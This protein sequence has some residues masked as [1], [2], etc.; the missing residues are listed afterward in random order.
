[1]VRLGRPLALLGMTAGIIIGAI[2]AGNAAHAATDQ[3]DLSWSWAD[4][5]SCNSSTETLSITYTLESAIMD[6]Y[7]NVRQAP[8]G[9]NCE[10]QSLAYDVHIKRLFPLNSGADLEW[11]AFALLGASEKSTSAPYALAGGALRPDGKPMYPV[12]LPAGRVQTVDAVLGAGAEWRGLEIG[13]GANLLPIDWSDGESG[14]T[15]HAEVAAEFEILWGALEVAADI[16]T[17]LGGHAYGS[18]RVVWRGF[19]LYAGLYHDW[20]LQ[21]VAPDAPMTAEF[22]GVPATLVGATEDE[23]KRIEAGITYAF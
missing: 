2:A 15:I 9:S 11:G 6:G 14:R 12:P 10:E 17:D 1:M 23:A 19:G 21:A 3:L 16:D 5:G 4:D 8:A 20:G 7:G 13:L 18:N 22:Y